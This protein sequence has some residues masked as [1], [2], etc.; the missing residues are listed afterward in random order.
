MCEFDMADD[1]VTSYICDSETCVILDVTNEV[2]A[3]LA[4]D[5]KEEEIRDFLLRE[6][7]CSY[8][9]WHEWKDGKAWL[10]HVLEM[11]GQTA[12]NTPA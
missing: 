11:L 5:L 3:L 1:V 10:E 12:R 6:I 2:E 8:C 4:L 9:Y 7:G